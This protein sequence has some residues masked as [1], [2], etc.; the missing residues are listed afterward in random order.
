[1]DYR[2]RLVQVYGNSEVQTKKKVDRQV[3]QAEIEI[4]LA[5]AE[6]RKSVSKLKGEIDD[7]KNEF[8]LNVSLLFDKT[9]ELE[10]LELGTNKLEAL[11]SELIP[12]VVNEEELVK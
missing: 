9:V 7:L 5:I 6:N 4:D 10:N 8:P 11:K 2:T 1:M 12:P 3:E